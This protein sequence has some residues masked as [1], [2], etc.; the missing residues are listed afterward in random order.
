MKVYYIT[1]HLLTLTLLSFSSIFFNVLSAQIT[2]DVLIEQHSCAESCNGQALIVINDAVGP[3]SLSGVPETDNGIST[4]DTSDPSSMSEGI[5]L[6]DLC[7][8]TYTIAI[9]DITGATASTTFTIETLPA[10]EVTFAPVYSIETGEVAVLAPIVSG[11]EAPYNFNWYLADDPT[12]IL[13]VDSMLIVDVYESTNYLVAIS[14]MNFCTVEASA[15]IEVASSV[16][17]LN[18]VDDYVYTTTNTPIVITALDN[19]VQLVEAFIT[20]F[21]T[22]LGTL[23]L[24]ADSSFTYIPTEDFVGIDTFSYT[25]C[26]LDDYCSTASVFIE[27]L[28]CNLSSTVLPMPSACESSCD[29]MI[30]VVIMDGEAPFTVSLLNGVG[31]TVNIFT[32]ETIGDIVINDLC[33]DN[34][35]VQITDG[36]ACQETSQVTILSNELTLLPT[37]INDCS[38][39]ST[40]TNSIQFNI[41]GPLSDEY[42]LEINGVVMPYVLDGDLPV[43]T[44]LCAGTYA[45]TLNDALGCSAST[46]VIIEA[47]EPI[48]NFVTTTISNETCAGNCDA[49]IQGTIEGGTPPYTIL[50]ADTTFYT[51]ENDIVLTGLCGGSS[52]VT[53][54]DGMGCSTD[55]GLSVAT[56]PELT[57]DLGDDVTA[58]LGDEV[59]LYADISGGMPPYQIIWTS[60]GSSADAITVN[61]TETTAYW[62]TVVDA[63][64]CLA[65]DNITVTIANNEPSAVSD[66]VSL[67]TNENIEF[68]VLD[69]DYNPN[70]YPLSVSI[71]AYPDFGELVFSVTG[72]MSYFPDTGFSGTDMLTYMA[73]DSLHCDTATVLLEVIACDLQVNAIAEQFDISLGDSV[74]LNTELIGG[75]APFT[76]S[77]SPVLN[78]SNSSSLTPTAMPTTT[79]IYTLTVTDADN[80]QNTAVVVVNVDD[81]CDDCVWPGDVNADGIVNNM[82][83]LPLGVAMD[84]TGTPRPDPSIDWYAHPANN[85][86][87]QFFADGRNFKHADCT[88]NGNVTM[89]DTSAIHENYMMVQGKTGDA[90]ATEGEAPLFIKQETSTYAPSERVRLPII[91]GSEEEPVEDFYALAFSIEYDE[92]LIDPS[93]FIFNAKNAWV[94][95]SANLLR[96]T[97]YVPGRVDI[98]LSRLNHSNSS[99]SGRIADIS[100]ILIENIDGKKETEVELTFNIVDV[101]CIKHNEQE[102]PLTTMPQTLTITDS[103]AEILEPNDLI[104]PNPA[105][106]QFTVNLSYTFAD[107]ITV[108]DIAGRPLYKV[109]N[110]ENERHRINTQHLSHGMYF[111]VIEQ[112]GSKLIHKLIVGSEK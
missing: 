81:L 21:T 7:A 99:G 33:A 110:I 2:I 79:T 59:T 85:W 35:F 92:T 3:V 46:E 65:V 94:A 70:D 24:N 42:T 100:F 43:I 54:L 17:T 45:I 13:S 106:N 4:T 95:D 62:I 51:S 77:W 64:G 41:F 37:V 87:G 11:G 44:N 23:I 18:A 60:A 72:D 89:I 40:C 83:I 102:I 108:F 1:Q 49:I 71:I 53:V 109:S 38:A 6:N 98:A 56:N 27:V 57:V 90:A 31:E 101:K 39:S 20:S 73:C 75:T 28:P 32:A 25:I 78:L 76:I 91:L 107:Q 86:G 93:T 29:G 5:V 112:N 105:L 69:N 48:T 55:F 84:A 52:L 34:Y 14:D 96:F 58:M 63:N 8:S 9:S 104:Y 16:E 97:R 88:G 111:V 66:S 22:A 74:V 10:I 82:D 68:N 15:T 61:P 67:F 103:E 80:C 19:D 50:I 30:E 26:T 36:L 47:Y 12:D